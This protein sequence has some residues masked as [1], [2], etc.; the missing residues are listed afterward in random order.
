LRQCVDFSFGGFSLRFLALWADD[1]A[2]L[3]ALQMLLSPSLDLAFLWKYSAVAGCHW[4]SSGQV[5]QCLSGVVFW[6]IL[7]FTVRLL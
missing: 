5:W 6:G 4:S 7:F 2:E 1:L 3:H